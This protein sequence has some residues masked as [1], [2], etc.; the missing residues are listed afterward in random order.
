MVN[1]EI[2]P[3]SPVPVPVVIAPVRTPSFQ[4]IPSSPGVMVGVDLSVAG[5]YPIC[6]PY[7]LVSDVV[8]SARTLSLPPLPLA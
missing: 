6:G 2:T 4:P 1:V 7:A 8:P 5:E 3:P